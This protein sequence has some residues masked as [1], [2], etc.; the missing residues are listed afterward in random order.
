MGTTGDRSFYKVL[1]SSGDSINGGSLAWSLPVRGDDGTWTPGAW[2]EVA[3]VVKCCRNGLHL[4]SEPINWWA[5][6]ARV[7]RAEYQGDVDTADDGD[8]D[9]IAVRR[10]RLVSEEEWAPHGVV[11]AGTHTF[12]GGRV[13]AYDSATVE[14]SGSATVRAYGSATVRAYGSANVVRSPYHTGG[15]VKLHEFA[16]LVDRRAGHRVAPTCHVAP[17]SDAPDGAA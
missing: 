2:H 7:F 3:G 17:W 12:T 11:S 13:R 14:A 16:A 6:G 15:F 10:A 5:E 4:T 1:S 8:D 9:K